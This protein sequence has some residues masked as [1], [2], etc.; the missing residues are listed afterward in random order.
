MTS[1]AN[2]LPTVSRPVWLN[3]KRKEGALRLVI[4]VA[5]AML[6]TARDLA[7]QA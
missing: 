3:L 1:E 2:G 4:A 5:F 6:N 7:M